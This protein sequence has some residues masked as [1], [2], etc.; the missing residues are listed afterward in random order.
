MDHNISWHSWHSCVWGKRKVGHI[1][2]HPDNESR[3]KFRHGTLHVFH[4]HKVI[5]AARVQ[6]GLTQQRCRD[7]LLE[8]P[9]LERITLDP[10]VSQATKI[11]S[12]T[13]HNHSTL[14]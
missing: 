9:I 5:P 11:P 4:V 7:L 10:E 3:P 13:R 8:D 14:A 12:A 1:M 2:N 6:Q